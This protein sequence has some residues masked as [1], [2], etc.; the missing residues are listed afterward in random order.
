MKILKIE[1]SYDPKYKK[2]C[3]FHVVADIHVETG[4]LWWKKQKVLQAYGGSTCW[5][6]SDTNE[7]CHTRW[8][9]ILHDAWSGWKRE[10]GL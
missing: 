1:M 5:Q 6:W 2:E 10:L 4:I 7:S 9:S 3:I 8:D